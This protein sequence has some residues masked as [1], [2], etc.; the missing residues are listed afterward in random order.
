MNFSG[1][2]ESAESVS[3]STAALAYGMDVVGEE[4][5]KMN[6]FL[7]RGVAAIEKIAE[8]FASQ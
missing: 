3:E 6:G 2:T 7:Q 1:L 5:K 8:K 4:L